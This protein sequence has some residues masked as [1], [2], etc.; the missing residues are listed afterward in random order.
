MKNS[1]FTTNLTAHIALSL[2]SIALLLSWMPYINLAGG[3]LALV[4]IGLS[5][6]LFMSKKEKQDVTIKF[7]VLIAL[8]ALLATLFVQVGFAQARK[9]AMG[10]SSFRVGNHVLKV[11]QDIT[12]ETDNYRVNQVSYSSD[13]AGVEAAPGKRFVAISLTIKN[14]ANEDFQTGKG[15]IAYQKD[16]FSLFQKGEKIPFLTNDSLPEAM[17]EQGII[18]VKESLT[19]TLYAEVSNDGKLVLNYGIESDDPKIQEHLPSF[20]VKLN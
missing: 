9:T 15:A 5:G 18:S 17:P 16:A 2:S 20:K 10:H 13:L 1:R 11:G 4:S 14:T 8:I 3:L 6:L 7:A 12:V 19:K